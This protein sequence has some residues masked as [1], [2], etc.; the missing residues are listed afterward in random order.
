[1]L[2]KVLSNSSCRHFEFG[3]DSANFIK[4]VFLCLQYFVARG[5]PCI[6]GSEMYF[7]SASKRQYKGGNTPHKSVSMLVQDFQIYA[8][9]RDG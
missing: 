7:P 5:A 9:H 4:K 6:N 3:I 1:M 2:K 8:C